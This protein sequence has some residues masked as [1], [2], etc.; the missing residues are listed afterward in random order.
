MAHH[1]GCTYLSPFAVQSSGSTSAIEGHYLNVGAFDG[2]DPT[3]ISIEFPEGAREVAFDFAICATCED[4]I[5]VTAFDSND[6]S[7]E[8]QIAPSAPNPWI[9]GAGIVVQSGSVSLNPGVPI[10][11]V[12]VEAFGDGTGLGTSAIVLD[13]LRYEP[14]IPESTFV[15]ESAV[16]GSG[17]TIGEQS[18]IRRDAIVGSITMIGDDVTVRRESDI[19]S[20]VVIDSGTIIGSAA[21]I[22]DNVHIGTQS[23]IRRDVQ[24]GLGSVVGSNTV[25][26]R[27]CEIGDYVQIGEDVIVRR[28]CTIGDRVIIGPGVLVRRN[29]T[30]GVDVVVGAGAV[31]RR[32]AVVP[33]GTLIPDGGQYPP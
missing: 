27:D 3:W 2:V 1:G 5:V 16:I 19:G 31:I 26:A 18:I 29:A 25:I 7:V 30:L 23:R 6:N 21:S 33:A 11:R 28:D 10:N 4:N 24:I 22:A 13:N 9:N 12:L 14:A 8:V 20:G 15:H 32:D 17:T